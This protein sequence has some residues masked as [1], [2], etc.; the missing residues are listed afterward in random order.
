MKSARK[1]LVLLFVGLLVAS[2][3]FAAG[4][5]EGAAPAASGKITIAFVPKTLGIAVFDAMDNGAKEAAKDTRK[6]R[7]RS[8]RV[9][10]H[11]PRKGRSRSS[12]R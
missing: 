3:G 9:R 5:K 12:P 6:R 1:V 11:R 10:A 7:S 4:Q 2:F 8:T